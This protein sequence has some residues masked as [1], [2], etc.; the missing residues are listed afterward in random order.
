MRDAGE[1]RLEAAKAFEIKGQVKSCEPY[2]SG[3][4]NNTF[5]LICGEG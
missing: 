1:K 5:L 2:G 4:I 3:H